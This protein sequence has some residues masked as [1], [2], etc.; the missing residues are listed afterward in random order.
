M[1][2]II[3]QSFWYRGVKF[4]DQNVKWIWELGELKMLMQCF[5]RNL[6]W[7]ILNEPENFWVKVASTDYLI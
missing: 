3:P 4:L 5:W 7:K 2:L 1:T 6:G